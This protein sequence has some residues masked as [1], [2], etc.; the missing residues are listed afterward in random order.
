MVNVGRQRQIREEVWF[1]KATTRRRVHLEQ[2]RMQPTIHFDSSCLR[3]ISRSDP[4]QAERHL[5]IASRRSANAPSSEIGQPTSEVLFN[6]QPYRW[7]PARFCPAECDGGTLSCPTHAR[8]VVAIEIIDRCGTD[9]VI[10][11]CMPLLRDCARIQ[12]PGRIAGTLDT[13]FSFHFTRRYP[14]RNFRGPHLPENQPTA[15]R[16]L[17]LSPCP[18]ARALSEARPHSIA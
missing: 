4:S 5:F 15:V 8:R 13:I 3:R 10:R 12:Q 17:R 11:H 16:Q 6:A 1:G 2:Y 9:S 7:L 18:S 14:T